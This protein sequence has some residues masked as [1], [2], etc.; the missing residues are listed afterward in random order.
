MF[1]KSCSGAPHE[2]VSIPWR[3]MIIVPQVKTSQPVVG[4]GARDFPDPGTDEGSK[5]VL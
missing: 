3:T 1:R 5:K 2:I 4:C